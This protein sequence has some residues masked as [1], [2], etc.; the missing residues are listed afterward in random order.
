MSAGWTIKGR[1]FVHCSCDYS[2]PCQFSGKPSHGD[3]RVVMAFDITEGHHEGTLLDRL[4]IASIAHWPGAIHEGHGEMLPIVDERASTE[5]R[6]ALLRIMTG[7]DTRPGATMFQVYSTTFDTV[8][9]A[10]FAPIELDMNVVA[11]RARL[12]V[13]GV[14]EARG[15]P[16]ANPLTGGE[17]R[18]RIHQVQGTEYAVAEVGRGSSKGS[19]TIALALK[20]THARFADIHLTQD[21]MR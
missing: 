11:R 20:D 17:H 7:L 2:C 13:P 1:E 18:A 16:I 8:H 15:E 19:G 14:I 9:E 4:R 6:A 5:Q 10:V 12:K 3:C 21:G